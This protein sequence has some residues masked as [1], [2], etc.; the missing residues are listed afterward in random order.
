MSISLKFQLARWIQS[1]TLLLVSLAFDVWNLVYGGAS[2]I[3][4]LPRGWIYIYVEEVCFM[5]SSEVFTRSRKCILLKVSFV[6]AFGGPDRWN[7]SLVNAG[8]QCS[9]DWK[10]LVAGPRSECVYV[11]SVQYGILFVTTTKSDKAI[12]SPLVHIDSNN[13]KAW[14]SVKWP[15]SEYSQKLGFQSHRNELISR[16]KENNNEG[17]N[18]SEIRTQKNSIKWE[19]STWRNS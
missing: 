5:R 13:S 2:K 1:F 15:T 8:L 16:A 12:L 10:R 18:R 11:W 7:L 6:S 14:E 9:T 17:D 4:F 19:I 3:I